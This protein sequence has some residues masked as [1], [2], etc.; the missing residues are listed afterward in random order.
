MKVKDNILQH[1]GFYTQISPSII[2]EVES[3]LLVFAKQK[4]FKTMNEP[5]VFSNIELQSAP[6][7]CNDKPI[8]V[9]LN[10]EALATWRSVYIAKQLKISTKEMYLC[11]IN[12]NKKYQFKN[13]YK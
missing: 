8:F 7:L 11:L 4:T 1:A 10:K 2:K 5:Y 6:V 12:Q 13:I 9:M 3:N